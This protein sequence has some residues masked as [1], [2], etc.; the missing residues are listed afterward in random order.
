MQQIRC[1]V[2]RSERPSK[3]AAKMKQGEWIYQ[4]TLHHYGANV[5][6]IGFDSIWTRITPIQ[7]QLEDES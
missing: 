4:T 2:A 3:T 6:S 1:F 7:E 5:T